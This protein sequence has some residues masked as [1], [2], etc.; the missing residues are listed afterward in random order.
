MRVRFSGYP[1]FWI[2]PRGY[3]KGLITFNVAEPCFA[4]L[5]SPSLG[6]GLCDKWGDPRFSTCQLAWSYLS[7]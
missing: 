6:D 2:F 5:G 1:I 3:L 7:D 4:K